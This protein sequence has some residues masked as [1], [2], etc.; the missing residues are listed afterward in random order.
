MEGQAVIRKPQLFERLPPGF[1]K[2]PC[3]VEKTGACLLTLGLEMI[4]EGVQ[5]CHRAEC[6]AWYPGEGDGSNILRSLYGF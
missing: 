4:I 3:A 6:P 1:L 2:E 5:R